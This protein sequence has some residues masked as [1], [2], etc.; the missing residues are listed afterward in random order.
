MCRTLA[1]LKGE[2]VHLAAQIRQI[3]MATKVKYPDK[4]EAAYKRGMDLIRKIM[5]EK[6]NRN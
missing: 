2:S 4:F 6:L 3:L 1:S 5:D